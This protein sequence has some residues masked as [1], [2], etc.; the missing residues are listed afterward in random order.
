MTEIIDNIPNGL[1]THIFAV[2]LTTFSNKHTSITKN[3]TSGTTVIHAR[4][5]GLSN[6]SGRR[7]SGSGGLRPGG[8]SG[9][10]RRPAARLRPRA[11]LPL[12]LRSQHALGLP[13]PLHVHVRLPASGLRLVAPAEAAC[14]DGFD[15][16]HLDPCEEDGDEDDGGAGDLE[17]AGRGHEDGLEDDAE[18]D[19]DG[20]DHGDGGCFL[21]LDGAWR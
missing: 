14:E 9:R 6:G 4:S 19:V 8:E 10:L 21:H 12:P 7:R 3:S 16:L 5:L 2:L 11:Q 20:A 17:A 15:V 18:G 13:R 1:E